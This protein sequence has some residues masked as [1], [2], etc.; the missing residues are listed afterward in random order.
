MAAR[1]S[2]VF[3]RRFFPLGEFVIKGKRVTKRIFRRS[4]DSARFTGGIPETGGA[5]MEQQLIEV[6]TT[7]NRQD[8][9]SYWRRQVREWRESGEKQAEYCRQRGLNQYTFYRWRRRLGEEGTG[10]VEVRAWG[11]RVGRALVLQVGGVCIE[12][13]R[14]S[15]LSLVR[16]VV[17]ALRGL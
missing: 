10:L 3:T 11:D 13:H 7:G 12:V 1:N 15:D 17:V 8:R 2:S 14:G 4:W 9:R 6:K 5:C 16:K